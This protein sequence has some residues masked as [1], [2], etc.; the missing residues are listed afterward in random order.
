MFILHKYSIY[1]IDYEIYC[2]II[3]NIVLLIV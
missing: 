3:L 1:C 2:Q